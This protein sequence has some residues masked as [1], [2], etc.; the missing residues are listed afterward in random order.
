MAEKSGEAVGLEVI[1][2]FASVSEKLVWARVAI[3]SAMEV[4]EAKEGAEENLAFVGRWRLKMKMKP[5]FVAPEAGVR[6]IE[7]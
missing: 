6:K 2:V 1:L 3:E 7:E 4:V 5:V